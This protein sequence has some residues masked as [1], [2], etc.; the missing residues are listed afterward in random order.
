MR[1]CDSGQSIPEKL[2]QLPPFLF[3]GCIISQRNQA[4]ILKICGSHF[5]MGQSILLLY[6]YS[7]IYLTLEI[8]SASSAFIFHTTLQENCY[9]W[10]TKSSPPSKQNPAPFFSLNATLRFSI[11]PWEWRLILYSIMI[12][13]N[14]MF[15]PVILGRKPRKH[16]PHHIICL[17]SI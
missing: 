11:Y 12:S 3:T 15:V 10:G 13:P 4:I 1:M 17:V 7:P 9:N 16:F 6:Y 5:Y 2:L 14:Q 8:L